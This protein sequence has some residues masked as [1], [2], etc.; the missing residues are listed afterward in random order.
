MLDEVHFDRDGL[1]PVVVQE[2]TTNEV[3]L[4]A[5]MNTLA[6]ERTLE[7]GLATFWS[8][9]R[10]KL[11]QKGETSGHV[12]E[13]V[14]LHVNCEGNS[15]LLRVRQ[16]GE[17]ACHDGYRSCYYRRLS[18]DGAW[19]ITQPRL[20]DPAAVYGVAEGGATDGLAKA[21]RRIYRA[22]EYLRDH[23][24]EE[25]SGTSRRLRH[26]DQPWLRERA[27]QELGELAE[28]LAGTHTHT[29]PTEDTILEGRQVCYWLL[30]RA[31]VEHIPFEEIAPHIH[32]RA[33]F[34][35]GE[36]LTLIEAGNFELSVMPL[37]HDLNTML[38][39]VGGACAKQ[40]ISLLTLAEA[41][42]ADLAR[43]EYLA[44]ALAEDQVGGK[45]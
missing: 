10:Q 17:A 15:L 43:K 19:E 12:Q 39:L 20:F 11:W 13:L 14:S 41:E 26:P 1:I 24:L 3:L 34:E 38:R 44:A 36:T 42:L 6:L 33:G 32:L 31:A 7:T 45:Q 4:L 37:L 27:A 25:V 9:S 21:F 30:L 5:F 16:R 8:R 23:D 22:Y 18:S 29:N 35:A 40:G 28:V 2:E